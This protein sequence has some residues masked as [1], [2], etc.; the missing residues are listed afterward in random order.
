[1]GVG[2]LL[3]TCWFFNLQTFFF[4]EKPQVPSK[5]PGPELMFYEAVRIFGI[6]HRVL[7]RENANSGSRLAPAWL[8]RSSRAA[9]AWLSCGSRITSTRFRLAPVDSTWLPRGSRVAPARL[10][11]VAPAMRSAWGAIASVLPR[12]SRMAPARPPLGL[13]CLQAD[14]TSEGVVESV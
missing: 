9:P 8:P 10:L 11:R 5:Y 14:K 6:R 2:Y 12:G 1:M 4:L 7:V 3:G 13:Q